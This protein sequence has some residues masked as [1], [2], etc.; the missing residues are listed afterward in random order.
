[1]NKVQQKRLEVNLQT[2]NKLLNELLG[3]ELAKKYKGTWTILQE[4]EEMKGV[5][6]GSKDGLFNNPNKKY[7]HKS[8]PKKDKDGEIINYDTVIENNYDAPEERGTGYNGGAGVI[9]FGPDENG[10]NRNFIILT[11]NMDLL[12]D[13]SKAMTRK[14]SDNLWVPEYN[15]GIYRDTLDG[16]ISTMEKMCRHFKKAKEAKKIKITPQNSSGIESR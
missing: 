2:A 14:D 10:K 11:C 16:R 12:K 3:E 15:A 4:Q 1:M 13:V 7:T 8:V 6:F 5:S 9:S